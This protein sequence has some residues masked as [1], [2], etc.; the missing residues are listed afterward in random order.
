MVS[1]PQFCGVSLILDRAQA[2]NGTETEKQEMPGRGQLWD[3]QGEQDMGTATR[4]PLLPLSG[5]GPL[6]PLNG[7]RDVAASSAACMFIQ[8]LP[9]ACAHLQNFPGDGGINGSTF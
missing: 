1:T 7:V 4:D 3:R 5:R 6:S 2:V 9:K 8:R